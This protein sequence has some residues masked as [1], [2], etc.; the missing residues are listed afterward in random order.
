MGPMYAGKTT[1]LIR[2]CN[3]KEA[4]GLK[5]KLY[6]YTLDKRFT[7]KPLVVSHDGIHGNCT[8]ILDARDIQEEDAK[9]I[10]IEEGQFIANLVEVCER[11]A[12][13][14]IHVIVAALSSTA[15]RTSFD[16]IAQLIPKCDEIIHLKAVCDVC[17]GE[18][19]SFSYYKGNSMSE[20][21]QD[22]GGKEKYLATCRVCYYALPNKP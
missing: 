3:R 13:K 2:L 19:G 1:E 6:K 15:Q 17:K 16:C 20:G 7:D 21:N 8:P 5:V 14:G 12:S 10:G 18:N 22:I 11:L 9:V 4:A